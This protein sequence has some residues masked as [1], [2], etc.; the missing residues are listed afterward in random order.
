MRVAGIQA[1]S[2]VPSATEPLK[3]IWHPSP[4][5][6]P[7]RNGLEPSMVVLHYTAMNNA[8]AALDRL[9]DPT[10][11][12]S[13]HYLIG[14]DGT[15]WQMVNEEERAWHAGAG[16]WR[17][18]TDI[19]SRSIGIELDNRGDHPFSEPQMTVLEKLLVE[20][21]TRWHIKPDAVIGHSDI[22]PSRKKDPGWKFDWQRLARANLSVW[23]EVNASEAV[24]GYATPE[25]LEEFGNE[26]ARFGYT[27]DGLPSLSLLDAFCQRF[28]PAFRG[29]GPDK[30]AM[31]RE[32]GA[33]F[34]VDRLKDEA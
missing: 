19:N 18:R 26:L 13:A 10:Y 28:A 6:G 27:V 5:F 30:L 4:N 31:A 2:A 12:V 21:M 33:R 15:L 16:S 3:P 32:L 14:A 8:Q 23:P 22:A 29:F 11:E 9:C 24:E 20:I 7:R 34:G 25:R 1:R 17:G